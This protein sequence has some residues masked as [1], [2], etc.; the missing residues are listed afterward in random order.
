MSGVATTGNLDRGS[1][2]VSYTSTTLPV[3][4]AVRQISKS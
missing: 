4:V 2:P 3:P 1:N